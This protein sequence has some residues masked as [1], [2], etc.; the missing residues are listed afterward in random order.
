MT[1]CPLSIVFVVR[2]FNIQEDKFYPCVHLIANTIVKKEPV[3][4]GAPTLPSPWGDFISPEDAKIRHDL[5]VRKRNVYT[6]STAG[7]LPTNIGSSLV[8]HI[9]KLP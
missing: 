4:V 5:Y 9:D 2:L 3:D 6:P 7:P 1:T 8:M